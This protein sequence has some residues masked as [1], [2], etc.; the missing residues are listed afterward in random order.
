MC[1]LFVFATSWTQALSASR[2]LLPSVPVFFV[3]HLR[4][5]PVRTV[6]WLLSLVA[7]SAHRIVAYH[8]GVFV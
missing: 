3:V 6:S 4:H 5:A 8:M 7:E 2:M 1:L